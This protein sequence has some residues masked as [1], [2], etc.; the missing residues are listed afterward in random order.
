ML[1][2]DEGCHLL[3]TFTVFLG[4]SM[5]EEATLLRLRLLDCGLRLQQRFLFSFSE[6]CFVCR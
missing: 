4:K 6:L 3:D 5:M 1:L 2:I